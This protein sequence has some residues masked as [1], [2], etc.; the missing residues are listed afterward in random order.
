MHGHIALLRVP[1]VCGRQ[2]I[3]FLPCS[4]QL[5]RLPLYCMRGSISNGEPNGIPDG[6]PHGQPDRRVSMPSALC[7]LPAAP[8]A[9]PRA[10][11]FGLPL[12]SVTSRLPLPGAR[13]TAGAHHQ[14]DG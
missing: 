8:G 3:T 11:V 6:V 9:Y 13:F 2:Q 7:P 5:T 14:P 1:G 4:T 12:F 10:F